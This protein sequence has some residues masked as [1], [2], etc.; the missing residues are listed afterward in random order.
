MPATLTK[1]SR[2]AASKA[3]AFNATTF[4][5]FVTPRSGISRAKCAEPMVSAICGPGRRIDADTKLIVTWHLGKRTRGDA[6]LF[7]RDL[8]KRIDSQRVQITTDGLGS[9]A[10][11]I[12]Q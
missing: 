1:T 11:P 12:Q 2:F 5:R 10:A 7:I 3:P 4:G 9:Y 6:N 8:S